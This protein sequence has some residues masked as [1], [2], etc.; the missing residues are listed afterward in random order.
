MKEANI[1]LLDDLAI[2][3]NAQIRGIEQIAKKDIDRAYGGI[4]RA[5]KGALVEKLCKALVKIAW[6]ELGGDK[7]LLSLSSHKVPI[8]LKEGYLKKIKSP[9]VRRHIDENYESFIYKAQV[10]VHVFIRDEFVLGIECKAYTENAMLKRILVDF[11]LLKTVY[12]QMQCALLQLE[13]QL[14]GDYSQINKE[15]I[16]GSYSTHVLM[17]YF[18][19][20]LNIMTLLEGER[21]PNNPIHKP[22]W[23][24]TLKTAVLVKTVE[25]IKELL[26][27]FI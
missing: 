5:K 11:S 16:Y 26:Q 15:V 3:A 10:D 22:E 2:E 27:P 18:N 1:R 12:P 7:K 17:S 25:K 13:S 14:T 20:D 24:K 23:F 6:D 19:V 4:V 9:E 21:K 8:A